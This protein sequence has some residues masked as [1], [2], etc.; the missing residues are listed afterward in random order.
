LAGPHIEFL[1]MKHS[2][3]PMYRHLFLAHDM[4]RTTEHD[5]KCS[6]KYVF[7]VRPDVGGN[8]FDW[9]PL[10]E[11]LKQ[12]KLLVGAKTG[13]LD[14]RRHGVS[15]RHRCVVDDQFAIGTPEQMY[16]YSSVYPDFSDFAKYLPL[17]RADF[18]GHTNERIMT[19]HLH[20]RGLGDAFEEFPHDLSLYALQA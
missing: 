2:T 14:K 4:V 17:Y 20:Y 18:G 16:A 12:G 19:A 11:T 3:G 10:L 6:Y 5:M 1:R 8:P 9:N 13:L 15:H 7:R